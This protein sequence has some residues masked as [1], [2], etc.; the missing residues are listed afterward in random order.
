M[1]HV[2]GAA[3]DQTQNKRQ[4]FRRVKKCFDC[5]TY[6][7][8]NKNIFYIIYITQY[9]PW[10]LPNDGQ[11][12]NYFIEITKYVYYTVIDFHHPTINTFELLSILALC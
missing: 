6:S 10:W 3:V 2:D 8:E 1:F 5:E 12:N 7:L 9:I 4:V 11:M